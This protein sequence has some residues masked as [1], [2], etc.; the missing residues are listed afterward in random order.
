MACSNP[1]YERTRNIGDAID[2][3]HIFPKKYCIDSKHKREKWNSII[4]K[5]PLSYRT[6]RIISGNKPGLYIEK[7]EKE[8]RIQKNILNN[9]LESHLI[10]PAYIRNNQFD[11]FIIERA[12]RIILV[13][14][15]AM[16]K[17]VVGKESEE[18]IK[19]FGKE[20]K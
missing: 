15:K 16:G 7:I 13:I 8:H 2:I 19:A 1:S 17:T 4:N 14:E 9:Y 10:D 12:K 6:N 20:L 5:A 11:E 18:T 3:H